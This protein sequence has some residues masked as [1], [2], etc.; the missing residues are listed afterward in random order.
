MLVLLFATGP[1]RAFDWQVDVTPAGELFPALQLSQSPRPR[2]DGVGDG[3]GLVS[4]RV[5]GDDLPRR[6]KLRIDTPGLLRPVELETR[7]GAGQRAIDLHPRLEWDTT[8]LR[9]LDA[10]RSQPMRLALEA[11]GATQTRRVD[12]RVHAL[13]DAPYFVREGRDRVD[14]GW[15]FA[16]YVDPND[17]VVDEILADARASDAGFERGSDLHRVGAVWAALER[18]GLRY[19]AGDPALSRGP[20]VWSQRVR[21]PAAVWRDRRANCIDS[22]VL[23][24]A[25][26]ERLGMR[27]LIVLVPGH[28]CVGYRTGAGA[29]YFETTLLGAV[30]GRDGG[31]AATNFA[32]ARAAG[33]ARWQRVAARLD[34]RHGPDYALIDIG[35]AR[36][37]GIIPIG[38]GE[39]ASRPSPEATP[40]PAGSSR[41]RGLP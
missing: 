6:L 22:S 24:A 16:G 12:V 5:R 13:D 15:A 25:V 41:Q 26:L 33:H 9:S 21:L 7:I 2:A 40:A 19:D 14:L 10:T 27:A 3:D 1:A 37:Y 39:R 28:A 29:Q 32:A 17:P 23:I 18:R 31:R 4:V 36:A 34:G 11:D 35:T 8:W 20:V 38:A 30:R